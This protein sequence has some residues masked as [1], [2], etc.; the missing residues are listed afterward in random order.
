MTSLS[1]CMS[2]SLLGWCIGAVLSSIYA[3]ARPEEGLTNLL[4]LTA[5][6]DFSKRDR[7]TLA[8]WCDEKYFHVEKI[9]SA[10]G[11]MPAE[12]LY[13]GAK[14]LKPIDNYLA[15]FVKLWDNLNNPRAVEA[16]QAMN[17]WVTDNIPMTGASYK[18]LIYDLYRDNAL[19]ENRL[20]IRGEV[21]DL[22]KITASLLTVIAEDDCITPPCQ[23]ESII[24]KVS[25]AD[26]EI[27][28]V[29]GGHIGIMAGRSAAQTTWPH[30]HQWLSARSK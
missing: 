9:L 6:L 22:R 19:I 7:I 1:G 12:L 25:S 3:A 11:N 4:L 20:R 24:E 15:N 21:V 30:I 10:F 2:F 16:W 5:P 26:K 14:S 13:Y 8:R 27:C 17:T 29:P 23:S 18:Q 28:R